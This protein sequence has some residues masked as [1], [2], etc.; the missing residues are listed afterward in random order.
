MMIFIP[1]AYAIPTEFLENKLFWIKNQ[2]FGWEYFQ[3][4]VGEFPDYYKRGS[5]NN[6]AFT[7]TATDT[8]WNF[9][10]TSSIICQF[11]ITKMNSTAFLV[12]GRSWVKEGEQ[13]NLLLNH[14]KRH[15]DI[16]EIHTR[17]IESEL[18]FKIL[19]CPNGEYDENEINRFIGHLRNSILDKNQQM[20]DQYDADTG[21]GNPSHPMQ[22]EWNSK[23][24]SDLQKYYVEN[25]DFSNKS[26]PK[27]TIGVDHEEKT[28]KYG[29]NVV[30]KFSNMKLYCITPIVAE[31]LVERNW[32]EII[33]L[34]RY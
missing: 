14:E 11:Q 1:F 31:K 2:H 4:T 23:I 33:L 5:S 19:S 26:I 13:S 8:E 30:Q 34:P 18:L 10:K 15:F 28:C 7:N 6:I 3:G 9:T 32:G 22:R 27:H 16:T 24:D 25:I 17:M 29:W 20:Q 21:N 12:M